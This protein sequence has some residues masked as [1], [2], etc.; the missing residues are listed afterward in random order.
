MARR[1]VPQCRGLLH[2]TSSELTLT[3]LGRF[4][5]SSR[6]LVGFGR[7]DWRCQELHERA[8]AGRAVECDVLHERAV[9]GAR[10]A[11]RT[12]TLYTAQSAASNELSR[13]LSYRYSILGRRKLMAVDHS[14][15]VLNGSLLGYCDAAAS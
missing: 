1:A 8:I 3:N 15:R 13:R 2:N 12:V 9:T 10:G 7:H 5:R 14:L 11:R 6:K 4:S